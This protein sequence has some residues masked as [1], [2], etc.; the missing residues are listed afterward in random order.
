[1]KRAGRT[2][3]TLVV[4]LWLSVAL[5]PCTLAMASVV[6]MPD[7]NCLSGHAEGSDLSSGIDAAATTDCHLPDIASQ[8]NLASPVFDIPATGVSTI[9]LTVV[10]A[11]HGVPPRS[12]RAS[13]S[14]PEPPPFLRNSVLLI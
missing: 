12:L 14:I 3:L 2:F 5:A 10:P 8:N 9:P 7:T 4:G 11:R 13:V 1:L 6:P